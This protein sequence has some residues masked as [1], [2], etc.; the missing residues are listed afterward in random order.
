MATRLWTVDLVKYLSIC[1]TLR[2][3]TVSRLMRRAIPYSRSLYISRV[4][5]EMMAGSDLVEYLVIDL[6]RTPKDLDD[7]LTRRHTIL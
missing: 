2:L 5:S 1:D 3:A 4:V 6:I 7:V